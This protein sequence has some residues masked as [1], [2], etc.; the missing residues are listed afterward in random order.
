MKRQGLMFDWRKPWLIRPCFR[1]RYQLRAACLTPYRLHFN[2]VCCEMLHCWCSGIAAEI[3]DQS[4]I[5]EECALRHHH[6]EGLVERLGSSQPVRI[7][8]VKGQKAQE[9]SKL[10]SNGQQEHRFPNNQCR[11]FGGNHQCISCS[12]VSEDNH[13]D[14]VCDDRTKW[15]WVGMLSVEGLT[16]NGIQIHL[17]Q[18]NLESWAVAKQWTFLNL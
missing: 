9:P 17:H 4:T 13:W 11:T 18:P 10:Y 2:V 7:L 14:G 6:Q 5:L 8:T 1:C 12:C 3:W 15:H 16:W